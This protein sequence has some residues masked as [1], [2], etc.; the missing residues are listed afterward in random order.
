LSQTLT[1]FPSNWAS[2]PV[3]DHVGPLLDV[4]VGRPDEPR[5]LLVHL[6]EAVALLRVERALRGRYGPQPVAPGHLV[7]QPAHRVEEPA[8]AE[9]V[10]L[11]GLDLLDHVQPVHV[12]DL[13]VGF[14]VD[15]ARHGAAVLLRGRRQL[16]VVA[17]GALRGP[18]QQLRRVAA[19]ALR[20]L[21]C[22]PFRR[23]WLSIFT[24]PVA[25]HIS[26]FYK[27]KTA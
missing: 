13:L 27:L 8:R 18:A 24:G 20:V 2:L 3:I 5:V 21:A 4:A 16:L 1:K 10:L 19:D 11:G 7:E 25:R 12:R 23:L 15:V 26:D 14:A 6:V 22:A 17:Q 9:V